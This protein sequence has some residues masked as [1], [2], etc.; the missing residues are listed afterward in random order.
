MRY[1]SGGIIFEKGFTYKIGNDDA[2]TDC[3]AADKR[4]VRGMR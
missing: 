1:L 3:R 2:G 4:G